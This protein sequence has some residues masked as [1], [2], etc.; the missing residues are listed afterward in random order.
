MVEDPVFGLLVSKFIKNLPKRM[1]A[2]HSAEQRLDWQEIAT[3]AHQMAGAA[4]GYGF[5]ELGKIAA[6]IEVQATERS[7]PQDLAKLIVAFDELCNRAIRGC[8]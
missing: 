1:A 8:A 6:G 4:G 7:S 3:L 2:L 5:P